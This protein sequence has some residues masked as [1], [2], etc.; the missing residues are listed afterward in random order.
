MSDTAP[1]LAVLPKRKKKPSKSGLRGVGGD[2]GLAQSRHTTIPLEQAEEAIAWNGLHLSALANLIVGNHPSRVLMGALAVEI[3]KTIPEE[4]ISIH[5]GAR[6]PKGK[7]HAI[8]V[9]HEGIHTNLLKKIFS[10]EGGSVFEFL[11]DAKDG[12]IFESDL[13]EK[14]PEEAQ[15]LEFLRKVW[16]FPIGEGKNKGMILL[17]G[18]EDAELSDE[19]KVAILD[20]TKFV[21]ILLDPKKLDFLSNEIAAQAQGRRISLEMALEE[22]LRS[23]T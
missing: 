3:G 20:I 10:L 4:A 23:M 17:W 14:F 21:A 22:F 15:T 12:P 7:S 1:Q 11:L 19:T 16:G 9:A 8:L 6:A 5:L 18:D 2:G 13:W